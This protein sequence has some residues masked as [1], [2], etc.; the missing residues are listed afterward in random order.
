M[1]CRCAKIPASDPSLSRSQARSKGMPWT[2]CLGLDQ[3][4]WDD[5][6]LGRRFVAR[7]TLCCAQ[8]AASP[9]GVLPVTCGHDVCHVFFRES[10]IPT[11][12][13]A[14]AECEATGTA[15]QLQQLIHDESYHQV[16]TLW[17]QACLDSTQ[18]GTL[19]QSPS[20]T[21]NHASRMFDVISC[22]WW[23]S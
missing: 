3:R 16:S 9:A 5:I 6:H 18:W 22:F 13:A 2:R 8:D 1:R 10:L 23:L 11:L 19:F 20:R 17:N 21:R 15:S 4:I 12:A 7:L 14:C